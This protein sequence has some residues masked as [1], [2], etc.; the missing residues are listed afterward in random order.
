MELL[1]KKIYG[2]K[3]NREENMSETKLKLKTEISGNV[4]ILHLDGEADAHT[5][6]S[7]KAE[8]ESI[9]SKNVRYIVYDCEKL[10]Y[11][12]S[13]AIG[14]SAQVHKVLHSRKGNMIF[15][16]VSPDVKEMLKL[17]LARK[18]QILPDIPAALKHIKAGS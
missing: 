3:Y 2:K 4:G 15:A 18:I 8:L 5:S 12:A 13:A 10:T 11:F 1:K 16:N 17:L 6:P 7:L 9:L 14:A